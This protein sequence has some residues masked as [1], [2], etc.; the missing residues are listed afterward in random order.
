MTLGEKQT[1]FARHFAE[2]ILYA[3]RC[4]YTVRIGEVQRSEAQARLNAANGTGIVNSL[5]RLKLAGDLMLFW[6]GQYLRDSRDY[7]RLGEYWKT[8]DSQCRWGGD[9]KQRPD[10]GH[11][12]ITHG[13]RS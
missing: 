12:S 1:L 2:L 9:F 4:G 6:E 7:W 5:H 13:G 3:F 8:L 10:G 11:F